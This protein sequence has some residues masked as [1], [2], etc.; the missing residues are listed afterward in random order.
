MVSALTWLRSTATPRAFIVRTT[1]RPKSVRPPWTR[2]S[3]AESAHA[4]LSLCVRVMYRTP[5]AAKAARCSSD[6]SMLCPPSIPS[7]AA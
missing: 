5:R 2:S 1:S 3:V 6:P 7:S 4:V